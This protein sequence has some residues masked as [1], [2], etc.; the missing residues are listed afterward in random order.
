MWRLILFLLIGIV[1]IAPVA[2]DDNAVVVVADTADV[3]AVVR[4]EVN[5]VGCF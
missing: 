2:D 4:V 1:A 5:F 3:L